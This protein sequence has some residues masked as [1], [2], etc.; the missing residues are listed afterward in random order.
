MG[1]VWKRC[2]HDGK[3]RSTGLPARGER[4][5][6]P[7]CRCT[8]GSWW[9]RTDLPANPAG[10]RRQLSGHEKTKT[11]AAEALAE[12]ESRINSGTLTDDRGL[13]VAD[14]L[15][16][17]L[18]AGTWK[19]KARASYASDVT[20]YL[21]PHLGSIRI[22]E[23]RRRDVRTMITTMAGDGKSGHVCDKARRT[24]RAALS[25]A[26]A[27][28]LLAANPA[29]GRITE[30]PRRPRTSGGVLEVD[31]V[32]RFLDH[33]SDDPLHSLLVVD[34]FTGL[35]RGELLGTPWDAVSLTGES[36]GDYPNIV[37]DQTVIELPGP[38]ACPMCQAGHRGRY[39]Q[40]STQL[41]PGAK[42]E[43]STGRW[44]PLVA[45]AVDSLMTH[46][47]RQAAWREQIGD[48]FHDHG[49]VWCD[50]DGAPMRPDAVTKRFAAVAQ[51]ANVPDL[52][53]K[54]L[55]R[56]AASMLAATGMPV[57]LIAIVLGQA[58]TQVLRQHYLRGMRSTLAEAAE[59]VARLVRGDG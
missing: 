12:A 9:W 44:V 36:P 51:A 59:D 17:W 27:D 54:T 28:E 22:R 15:T 53:P 47:A 20:L 2:T 34:A 50:P 25:A 3:T 7:A 48:H 49:L 23:L 16:R 4:P 42:S 45:E 6:I 31:Q 18:A 39:I 24:L 14:W 37:I 10:R 43:A 40:R 55:R 1:S 46:R 56:G 13:T 21:V 57:E 8:G 33:N 38:Q 29:D 32:R 58:H 52:T 41:R 5:P 19:P 35:R 26:I 30:T 11:L